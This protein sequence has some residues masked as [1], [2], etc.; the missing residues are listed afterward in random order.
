MA[1]PIKIA[2]EPVPRVNHLQMQT[3]YLRYF[4]VNSARANCYAIPLALGRFFIF[5][6]P[7]ADKCK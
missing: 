7:V 2:T 3:A 1:K 4:Y 5:V 6:L